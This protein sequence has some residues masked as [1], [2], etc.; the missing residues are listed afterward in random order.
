MHQLLANLDALP[1]G[2]L[3]VHCASGYRASIAASLLDR[4]GRDV[5]FIDD[6]FN[7]AIDLGLTTSP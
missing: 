7:N 5:V 1:A 6:S 4:A 3:W 2:Q